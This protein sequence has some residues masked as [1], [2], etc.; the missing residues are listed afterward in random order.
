[1]RHLLSTVVKWPRLQVSWIPCLYQSADKYWSGVRKF[2]GR[3]LVFSSLRVLLCNSH[4]RN[5][6]NNN[7]K[8]RWWF[9]VVF[10]QSFLCCTTNIFSFWWDL[11]ALQALTQVLHFVCA[12]SATKCEFCRDIPGTEF[13]THISSYNTAFPRQKDIFFYCSSLKP[14]SAVAA[15]F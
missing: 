2:F 8:K 15:S 7:N 1:M 10:V 12:N 3:S 5:T 11:K 6:G 4:F 14:N 13:T 9:W